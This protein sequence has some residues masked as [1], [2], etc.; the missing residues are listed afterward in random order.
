MI[1]SLNAEKIEATVHVEEIQRENSV[2][3]RERI[4]KKNVL[5]ILRVKRNKWS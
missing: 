5:F 4:D 3:A 2:K 1:P